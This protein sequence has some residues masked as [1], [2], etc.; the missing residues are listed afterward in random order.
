LIG[1]RPTL[2]RPVRGRGRRVFQLC[3][4]LVRNFPGALAGERREEQLVLRGKRS[5]ASRNEARR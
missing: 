1:R 3:G 2:F 4:D 5:A